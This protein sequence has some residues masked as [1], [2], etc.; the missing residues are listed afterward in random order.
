MKDWNENSEEFADIPDENLDDIADEYLAERE[1]DIPDVPWKEDIENIT[2]PI[3]RE[4]QIERAE[5]IFDR[6]KGLD[7]RFKSGKITGYQYWAEYDTGIQEEKIEAMTRCSLES[8]GL[9]EERFGREITDKV[10]DRMSD[11]INQL[12]THDRIDKMIENLGPEEAQNLAD[13]LYLGGRLSK[14][15]YDIFSHKARIHKE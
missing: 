15:T 12:D 13:D 9:T 7:E 2:D 1:P 11:Q 3:I 4:K 14:K 10:A 8:I 6:G 5:N